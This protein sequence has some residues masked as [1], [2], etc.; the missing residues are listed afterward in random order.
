MTGR[1]PTPLEKQRTKVPVRARFD[2]K[3]T[4]VTETGCW[5]WEG[6]PNPFGYGELHV[7]GHTEFAHRVSWT[8]HRGEIPDGLCVLHKCDTP[9]CVNPDHLFLGTRTDNMIDKVKKGRQRGGG[10]RGSMV[11]GAKLTEA[12]AETIKA[13]PKKHGSGTMLARKFGVNKALIGRIRHGKSWA[14]VK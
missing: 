6:A 2:S 10:L 14:H 11:V 4:P 8:L 7:H 12:D 3:Y 5:L 9:A 13:W 1:A